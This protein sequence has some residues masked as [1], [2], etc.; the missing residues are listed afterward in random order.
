MRWTYDATAGAL[1]VYL[2]GGVIDA[3]VELRPGVIADIDLYGGAVGV[4]LL[5]PG[6]V[7]A[8]AKMSR[9]SR[10]N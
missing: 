8:P 9:T 1:Y 5:E 6:R 4:E 7:A 3:Q 10:M 2:R